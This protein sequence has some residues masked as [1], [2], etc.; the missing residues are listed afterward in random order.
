MDVAQARD[1]PVFL[2][3][4]E[5]WFQSKRL[6]SKACDGRICVSCKPWAGAGDLTQRPRASR[7]PPGHRGPCWLAPLLSSGDAQRR[8]W[9]HDQDSNSPQLMGT[10]NATGRC[11]W[12]LPSVN[13]VNGTGIRIRWTP[14]LR[15][16]S[17]CLPRCGGFWSSVA[18][19]YFKVQNGSSAVSRK[20]HQRNEQRMT[21]GPWSSSLNMLTVPLDW[22]TEGSSI[23]KQSVERLT[24][25]S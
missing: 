15:N 12:S 3:K 23:L 11:S 4:Q 22:F 25:A 6:G 14:N 9:W 13:L 17:L 20:M 19:W 24:Q 8:G 7:S 16:F 5:C 2:P 18:M 21:K 1:A 10:N